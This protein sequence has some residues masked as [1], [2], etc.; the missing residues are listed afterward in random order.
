MEGLANEEVFTNNLYYTIQK[1]IKNN[2][3]NSDLQNFL[4][5]P[6]LHQPC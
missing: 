4:I 1:I 2:G 6:E 5:Y 3:M